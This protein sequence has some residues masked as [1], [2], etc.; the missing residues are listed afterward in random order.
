MATLAGDTDETKVEGKV[1]GVIRILLLLLLLLHMTETEP[2]LT[3][4][5][6]EHHQTGLADTQPL[7]SLLS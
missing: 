3:V 6:T 7:A 5:T 2:V 1:R 4:L